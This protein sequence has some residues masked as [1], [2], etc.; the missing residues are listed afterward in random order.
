MKRGALMPNETRI[1]ILDD[2]IALLDTLTD[3]LRESGYTVYPVAQA[4]EASAHLRCGTVDLAIL[5]VG[6]HGLRIAREATS[7][8]VAS[9][10]MS[11]YPVILEIGAI[12]EVLRKPFSLT[13][14]RTN[15]ERAMA[16]RDANASAKTE[17]ALDQL[18]PEPVLSS[19]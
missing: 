16:G 1:L 14:L 10:L 15:I 6:A 7:H 9:I 12:G 5:D 4:E 18:A 17:R 8:G 2:E 11:G 19:A 13:T 3:F